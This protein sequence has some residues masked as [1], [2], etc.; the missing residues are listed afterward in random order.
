MVLPLSDRVKAQTEDRMK[1]LILTG[2]A[3]LALISAA[4]ATSDAQVRVSVNLGLGPR[5]GYRHG[6]VER[7]YQ[8]T[9]RSY[10]GYHGGYYRYDYGYRHPRVEVVRVHRPRPVVVV[11]RPSRVY[12]TTTIYRGRGYRH[13]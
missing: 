10:Y 1:Q 7:V 11:H 6:Y 3:T 9:P 8:Y 5:Y 12:R 13:R 4:P 2:L